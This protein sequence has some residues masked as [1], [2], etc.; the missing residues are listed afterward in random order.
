MKKIVILGSTGYIGRQTLEIIRAYPKEFR[1]I[2]LSANKNRELLEKQA[3][4]FKPIATSIGEKNLITTAALPEADLVVVAV[5]G[6]AGLRPTLAA[7]RAKKNIALATKE[8]LVVAGELVMKEVKK[9]KIKL[10]PLD[11]EHSAIFQC[12]RAGRKK[13]IKRIILTMGKGRF[14]T[15]SQEELD[16][17]TLKNIYE[18]PTWRMG[19]KITIDSATCLN[20]S[21]EVIEAKWLFDLPKEKISI[22]VHPERLCHSLVEFQDGSIIGEFGSPDMRRYIQHAL[23][24]PERRETRITQRID[25]IDK[26]I[27]FEPAPYNKFPGLNLGFKAL[28]AG[29]TL[30][31]VMH[32]ADET[33]VEA[34]VKGEIRFTDIA[35]IVEETMHNHQAIKNP[36]LDELLM[37]EQWGRN[38]AGKLIKH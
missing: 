12:L 34:F 4:E 23:F 6:L 28:E 24:Y 5:V 36:S 25:L 32:G 3:I 8:V 17:V 7:I 11:S 27:S 15:M 33:T 31:A 13:E 16:R 18:H 1:V 10:I 2:G 22:I 14:A 9:N 38:Y 30:P 37:G 35:N 19:N 29:G 21:F 20:K 26:K